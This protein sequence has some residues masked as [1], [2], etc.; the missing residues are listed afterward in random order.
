MSIIIPKKFYKKSLGQH[1]L[2]DEAVLNN[3]MA[4]AALQAQDRVLEIGA[5]TGILSEKIIPLVKKLVSVELDP[6]F[7]PFLNNLSLLHP[8]FQPIFDDIL[9]LDLTLALET[10][11]PKWRVMG[12]I[13]YGITAPLL[14]KLVT[15]GGLWLSDAL[16]M[17]QKEVGERLIAKSGKAYGSLSIFV[18]YHCQVQYLFTVPSSAFFP[19]PKVESCIMRLTFRETPPYKIKNLKFF[20]F[21]RSLFTQRRKM[22]SN[23]LKAALPELDAAQRVELLSVAG[24]NPNSRVEEIPPCH[25]AKLYEQTA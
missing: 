8:N 20:N 7:K 24:I 17:L 16:L 11:P 4:E 5:G 13:P 23:S 15:L 10:P 18:H 21:T 9:T 25:L 14:N 19:P 6:S 2:K 12:N 22:I 1:L 3:I